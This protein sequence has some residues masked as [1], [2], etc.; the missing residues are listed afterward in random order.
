MRLA[1][2]DPREGRHGAA[3]RFRDRLLENADLRKVWDTSFPRAAPHLPTRSREA[4]ARYCAAVG[5]IIR[6]I[7]MRLR[8]D[9]R[10]GGLIAPPHPHPLDVCLHPGR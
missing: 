5:K 2:F 7:S 10:Y 3:G 4:I 6:S 8:Q 9:T 1:P